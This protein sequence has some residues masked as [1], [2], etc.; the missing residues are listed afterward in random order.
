MTSQRRILLFPKN[1]Q[2]HFRKLA[3]ANLFFDTNKK[4]LL[5]G[6]KRQNEA[7]EPCAHCNAKLRCLSSDKVALHATGK[8]PSNSHY[9][10]L[11]CC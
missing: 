8:F 7:T 3:G 11:G 9:A 5:V 2:T 10:K 1:F 4:F 6:E